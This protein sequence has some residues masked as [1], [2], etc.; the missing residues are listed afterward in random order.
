M[1]S[2]RAARATAG[3]LLWLT[4]KG[5]KLERELTGR[6]SQRFAAPTAR[7]RRRR[8]RRL[9]QVLL[10]LLDPPEPPS[11]TSACRSGT[12]SLVDP[13]DKPH[14]LVVDDDTRLREPTEH[15]PVAQRLFVRPQ[16][17]P[18]RRASAWARS[19]ST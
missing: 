15:V 1:S 3:R 14:V 4:E 13:V 12:M 5:A 10:G 9:P 16:A 18:P 8:R 17:A 11:S 19:T 6:Q 7:D 2:R